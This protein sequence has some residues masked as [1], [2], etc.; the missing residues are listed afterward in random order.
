MESRATNQP[1]DQSAARQTLANG[2]MKHPEGNE[3]SHGQ[4]D[5]M[6]APGGQHVTQIRLFALINPREAQ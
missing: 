6:S 5:T 1:T 2:A 4:D 3:F